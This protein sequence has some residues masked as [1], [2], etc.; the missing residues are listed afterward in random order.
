MWVKLPIL[1]EFRA[2][3]L[4]LLLVYKRLQATIYEFKR[5]LTDYCFELELPL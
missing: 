1:K 2:N 5:L 3:L 4:I